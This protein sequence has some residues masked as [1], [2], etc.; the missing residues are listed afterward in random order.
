MR[1]G[2]RRLAA[3][4][5]LV[6]L[7]FAGAAISAGAGDTV[8]GLVEGST[9][10]TGTCAEQTTATEETTTAE[11]GDPVVLDPEPGQACVEPPAESSTEPPEDVPADV[12][13]EEPAGVPNEVPSAPGELPASPGSAQPGSGAPTASPPPKSSSARTSAAP[14][15]REP[16]THEG[17]VATIWLHRTLPDPTPATARLSRAFARRLRVTSAEAGVDWA[18]VL[19]VLRAR[20]PDARMRAGA[21][22]HRAAP[23]ARRASRQSAARGP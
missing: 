21:G 2:S 11:A 6:A 4:F 18:L 5:A 9:E 13:E 22:R 20:N 15:A 12:P 10:T 19:A 16:E 23:A 3:S 17:G 14:P 8:T 7:F 1:S